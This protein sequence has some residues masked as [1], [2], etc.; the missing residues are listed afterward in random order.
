MTYP[1]PSLDLYPIT[2]TDT[3][4]DWPDTDTE[5]DISAHLLYA[6]IH[7]GMRFYNNN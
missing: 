7:W 6:A 4:V 5:N 2:D 1:H 3:F